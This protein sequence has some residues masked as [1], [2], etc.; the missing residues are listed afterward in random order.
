MISAQYHNIR[1]MAKTGQSWNNGK[2]LL[3][4]LWGLRIADRYSYETGIVPLNSL[5]ILYRD[6]QQTAS[7]VSKGPGSIVHD[8]NKKL[9]NIF[10]LLNI[11]YSIFMQSYTG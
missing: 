10:G 3:M 8:R 4:L 1:T 11:P 7:Y 9:F 5:L 6:R 2:P